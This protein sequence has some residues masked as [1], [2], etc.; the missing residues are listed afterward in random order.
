MLNRFDFLSGR[1]CWKVILT[2]LLHSCMSRQGTLETSVPDCLFKDIRSATHLRKTVVSSYQTGWLAAPGNM[3]NVSFRGRSQ[4]S[5]ARS[6]P[7]WL[8]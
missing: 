4:A 1:G 5:C 8:Q 3:D 6:R 2:G 7:R